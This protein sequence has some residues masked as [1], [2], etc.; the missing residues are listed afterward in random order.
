MVHSLA[1]M[2]GQ[3]VLGHLE[4]RIGAQPVGVVA[5]L[6]A[7]GNHLHADAVGSGSG[8]PIARVVEMK[9]QIRLPSADILPRPATATRN[10]RL[11]S[12]RINPGAD[13]ARQKDTATLTK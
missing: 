4:D 8:L 11:P 6:V 7:G 1:D 13:E 12:R 10:P 5:V 9:T 3:R 2:I